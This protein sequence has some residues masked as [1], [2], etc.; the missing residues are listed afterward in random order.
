LSYISCFSG[1]GGLEGT[2][3]PIAVCDA[4]PLCQEVLQSRFPQAQLF[5]DVRAIDRIKAKTVVGGW[6]CQD[7]SIAGKQR[8]LSGANSGLFYDFVR[9]AV[10]SDAQTVIAE[11]VVNLLK[12]EK[13]LVFVEVIRELNEAGFNYISWRTLNARE[14]GLPHH[15]NRVFIVASKSVEPCASLFRA[16]PDNGPSKKGQSAGFYWT[17]GTHSICYSPGYIPT[18]KIGSS[19]PIPVISPPALHISDYVRLL[20]ANEAL[21]LQ[22]FRPETFD[23]IADYAKYKMAGN[24]VASPVGRF[25]VDGVLLNADANFQAL[26]HQSG[27]FGADLSPA[28]IPGSGFWNGEL[29][30]VFLPKT[31]TENVASNLDEFLDF[32]DTRRLNTRQASGLLRRLERSGTA[33]PDEVKDALERCVLEKGP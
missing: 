19:K 17:A 9:V 28:R 24:A 4:D 32:D 1:I 33:C 23:G 15:R 20:S 3:P 31:K 14:F 22:G 7:L 2:E 25:V 8:G 10:S 12:I 6:P 27:L 13:G 18:L 30:E 21:R 29:S 16:I 26:P 5:L 11:N